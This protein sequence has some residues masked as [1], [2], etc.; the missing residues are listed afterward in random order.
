VAGA[1]MVSYSYAGTTVTEPVN[2]S[3][4]AGATYTY[5]FTG[6]YSILAAGFHYD[7]KSWVDFSADW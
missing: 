6:G 3:I 1:F 4:A 2:T 5:T 7:F